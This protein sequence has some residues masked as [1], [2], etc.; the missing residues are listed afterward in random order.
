MK[1]ALIFLF[2]LLFVTT[3]VDAGIF[4]SEP[5]D[6]LVTFDKVIMLK[7][8]GRDLSILKV[9]G[10]KI[11]VKPEGTF[12]CGLALKHGKNYVEVRA[13]DK[14]GNHF[15]KKLRILNLKTYPDIES[16][17]D[18]VKH[19]ARSPIIYLSTFGYI[20]GYPDG[21][22]YPGIP[23][24]RGEFASWIAR[25]RKLRIPKLIEDV[26]YDVPKEHWR[27]PYIKAV[28]DAEIMS[29]YDNQTFGINDPI[30]RRN[31]ANVV[32]LAEGINVV[33][34][35]RP[36]FIDVPK[37]EKGALP[38]YI[39]KE[40][41]LVRGVYQDIPIF[42]PDRA[43][44]RAEAAVL[45]ARFRR[46]VN[47]IKYLFNFAKGFSA[48]NY[49]QLNVLPEIVSFTA[50]PKNLLVGQKNVVRLKVKLASRDAFSPISKVKVNLVQIGGLPDVEM[51]DNGIRGDEAAGDLVYSL[52][53][54][55]TPK[56][57][58]RKTLA[59]T[60]IDRLGWESTKQISLM[61]LE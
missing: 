26:F 19:W 14:N 48:D 6:K 5:K 12:S 53:I 57:S 13:L 9:N 4:I 30:S 58:G 36:I 8:A 33:E 1:R 54:S 46:S 27:A 55:V 16:L 45:L 32:V 51:F 15:V 41:G 35:V 42:D 11:K 52:N 37:E 3:A 31:A 25:I 24:T 10:Q 56:E 61:I 34:K 28:V 17:Y 40:K 39:A 23:V 2:L 49:C 38:I 60:V 59:V 18:G 43:L 29:P 50:E 47:A 20:E 22:Y 21:N 7:G 44:T